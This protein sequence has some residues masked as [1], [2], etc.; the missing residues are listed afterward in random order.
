MKL[1]PYYKNLWHITFSVLMIFFLLGY[2]A[3]LIYLIWVRMGM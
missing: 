3:Q 2:P 1:V